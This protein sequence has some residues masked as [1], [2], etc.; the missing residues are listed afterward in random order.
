M[1]KT[2]LQIIDA[3]GQAL[4]VVYFGEVLF[5]VFPARTV[6]GG[7]PFNAAF[8]SHLFGESVSFVSSVGQDDPGRAIVKTLSDFGMSSSFVQVHPTLPT[9][10]VSIT[11]PNGPSCSHEF[12]I[13]TN[14]AYDHIFPPPVPLPLFPHIFC[15]GTL[16]QRSPGSSRTLRSLLASLDRSRTVVFLDVNLRRGCYTPESVRY[17]L[18]QTTILKLNEEEATLPAFLPSLLGWV[19]PPLGTAPFCTP[20]V[21]CERVLH[22]FPSI[23]EIIVTLGADGAFGMARNPSLPCGVESVQGATFPVKELKDTV[24]CGDA[25]TAGFLYARLRDAS[26]VESIRMGN[27]LGAIVAG[28]VGGTQPHTSEDVRNMIGR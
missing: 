14:V 5:D 3:P 28:Q 22:E 27:A 21:F 25:F 4:D 16:I 18:S 26:L 11:F 1:S 7:A 6:L 15:F 23:R 9:G 17:S 20:R 10:Y 13:H 8:R 19:S 24:G 12:E 2:S